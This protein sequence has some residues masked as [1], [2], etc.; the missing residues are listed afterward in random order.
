MGTPSHEDTGQNNTLETEMDGQNDHEYALSSEALQFGYKESME[1][2]G[3]SESKEV[4]LSLAH[5]TDLWEGTCMRSRQQVW[6]FPGGLHMRT[7]RV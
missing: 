5:R 3:I 4:E 6:T 7:L 2:M 1:G